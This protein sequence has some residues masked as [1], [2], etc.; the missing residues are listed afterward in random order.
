MLKMML[1]MKERIKGRVG[2][3]GTGWN[4]ESVMGLL[5]PFLVVGVLAGFGWLL[6]Q[7]LQQ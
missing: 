3:Y 2:V 1:E 7:A 4:P 5:L 6:V